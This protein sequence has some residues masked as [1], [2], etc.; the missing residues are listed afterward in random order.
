ML[1]E[2]G[3]CN[4]NVLR[5][6]L[7]KFFK[8]VLTPYAD[9]AT[10]IQCAPENYSWRWGYCSRTVKRHMLQSYDIIDSKTHSRV[11]KDV[12]HALPDNAVIADYILTVSPSLFRITEGQDKSN[13]LIAKGSILVKFHEE[14][15][16]VKRARLSVD[17][18][19]HTQQFAF[20]AELDSSTHTQNL[21]KN[22]Q[23]SGRGD[24]ESNKTKSRTTW[25][26][27]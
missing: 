22:P 10:K 16:P 17:S 9:L 4:D 1:L 15:S 23:E 2:A 27:F 11:I 7:G 21:R 8:I 6:R 19:P 25:L 24:T 13:I 20:K 3:F 5:D 14:D 18:S 26:N 12:F